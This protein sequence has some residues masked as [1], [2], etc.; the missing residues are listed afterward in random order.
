[1][2]VFTIN[3]MLA[4]DYC[5]CSVQFEE[6]PLYI[7][8]AENFHHK[9]MLNSSLFSPSNSNSLNIRNQCPVSGRPLFPPGPVS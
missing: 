4:V 8:F 7:Y 6:V 9:Y 3:I 1:M 2:Q 5:R